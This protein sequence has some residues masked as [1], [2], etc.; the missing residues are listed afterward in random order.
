MSKP[1][2]GNMLLTEF[3]KALEQA[4]GDEQAMRDGAKVDVTVACSEHGHPREGVERVWRD[5]GEVSYEE[6]W[7]E[8]WCRR[9]V[10]VL[11]TVWLGTVL[12]QTTM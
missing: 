10:L 9:L 1:G 6:W 8:P 3:Q 11:V 4:S 5:S 2:H 12:T 7:S